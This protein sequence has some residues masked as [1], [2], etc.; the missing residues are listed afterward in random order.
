MAEVGLL[1]PGRHDQAV[2][3]EVLLPP[4]D[5]RRPD[6]AP[7]EVEARHIRQLDVHVVVLAQQVTKDVGDLAR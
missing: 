6:D 7:V 4:G 5:Q 2:V 1:D 3:R